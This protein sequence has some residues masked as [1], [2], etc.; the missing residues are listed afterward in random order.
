MR[1]S[2]TGQFYP[3]SNPYGF[4][5]VVDQVSFSILIPT[6]IEETGV[7]FPYSFSSPRVFVD[8]ILNSDTGYAVGIKNVSN[9]GYTAIFSDIIEET[10]IYL[11]TLVTNL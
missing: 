9:T 2:D 5:T 10:G 4:I 3:A 7:L 11:Q 6:G 1:P 8:L